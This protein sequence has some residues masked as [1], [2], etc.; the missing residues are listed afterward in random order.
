MVPIHALCQMAERM[1]ILGFHLLQHIVKF[2]NVPARAGE[3]ATA[4]IDMVAPT[5]GQPAIYTQ[6]DVTPTMTPGVLLAKPEI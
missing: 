2:D 1:L 5:G 6:R 3:S 4:G